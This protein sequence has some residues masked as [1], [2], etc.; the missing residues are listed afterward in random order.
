MID[1]ISAVT[2]AE[3]VKS[4]T[5]QLTDY[6]ISAEVTEIIE[7]GIRTAIRTGVYAALSANVHIDGQ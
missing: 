4:I 5:G 6:E 2:A 1:E 3:A 7:T